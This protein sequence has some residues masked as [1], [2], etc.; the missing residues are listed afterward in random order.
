MIILSL[1][2]ILKELLFTEGEV[3]LRVIFLFNIVPRLDL[4]SD[5][6]PA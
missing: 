1:G 4:Y 2:D 5:T 6:I 3:S